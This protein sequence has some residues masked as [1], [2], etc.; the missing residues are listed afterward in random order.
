MSTLHNV[1]VHVGT[2][3]SKETTSKSTTV[4]TPQTNYVSNY[5]ST[6]RSFPGQYHHVY[7]NITW[8]TGTIWILTIAYIL[9][10]YGNFASGTIKTK[11]KNND[12]CLFVE[13]LRHLIKSVQNGNYNYPY[14]LTFLA[15]FYTHYFTW[16]V[17]V[18]YFNDD[19]YEQFYHQT[20]FTITEIYSTFQIYTIA[21]SKRR[22][23]ELM[24]NIEFDQSVFKLAMILT[25]STSHLTVGS[26]DQFI[27][28]N[29]LGKGEAYQRYRNAGLIISDVV[30]VF[31][32]LFDLLRI[33]HYK[34]CKMEKS[35]PDEIY[36]RS[37]TLII[38]FI[39]FI[40]F[41]CISQL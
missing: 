37:K 8:Q 24:T 27:E 9:T 15:S 39:Y 23:V 34:S 30:G 12:Q 19:Y 5:V 29:V 3:C 31:L 41:V 20:L 32:P 16:W 1:V 14:C 13:C 4:F 35:A 6:I 7:F 22:P 21:R 36:N 26:L 40:V 18:G 10:V 25:I 17:Y 28:H 33:F 38:C 2:L 11:T